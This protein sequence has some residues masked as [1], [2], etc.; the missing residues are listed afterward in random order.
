MFSVGPDAPDAVVPSAVHRPTNTSKRL[1][2]GPNVGF[3]SIAWTCGPSEA[4]EVAISTPFCAGMGAAIV[5][6]RR[7]R[8]RAPAIDNGQDS[9]EVMDEW[10]T[11]AGRDTQGR[12]HPDGG[13]QARQMDD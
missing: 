7:C 6:R 8:I 2:S 4:E 11:G 12:I 13:R 3:T 9:Q 1:C 5:P 10:C